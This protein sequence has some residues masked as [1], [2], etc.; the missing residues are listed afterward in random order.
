VV[1]S[2]A[3]AWD[4]KCYLQSAVPDPGVIGGLRAECQEGPETA[5]N[6][7]L[8]PSDEHR[9]LLEFG[10]IFGGLPHAVSED[11]PLQVFTAHDP[12][13][14]G[15]SGTTAISLKPV[16][17][18]ETKRVQD[19]PM[20]VPEFAQLPDHAFALWDWALGNETCPIDSSGAV[21]CHE[22][23]THMGAVN[24]NHFPPQSKA[25]YTYYHQLALDRAAACAK[26]AKRLHASG[27]RFTAFHIACE[28]QALM[29][30][31]IGQHFLQ[32]AWASGHMWERWGSPDRADFP[33]MTEALMVA[34]TSGLIHGARAVLEDPNLLTQVPF[35]SFVAAQLIT[36]DFDDPL[37]APGPEIGFRSPGDAVPHAGLG[38]L[39]LNNLLVQQG[40][41]RHPLL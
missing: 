4:S 11:I 36:F 21:A 10:R 16:N 5:R 14:G 41:S 39:Y 23:K 40:A 20:S 1:A 35:G 3:A 2:P 37:N 17:F 29:L 24:S 19:R 9:A 34:I 12:V 26:M 25:F 33:S 7:W 27:D 15:A 32:D 8:G 30:E 6:R 13:P 22:F 28:R 38:D 18:A 31:A